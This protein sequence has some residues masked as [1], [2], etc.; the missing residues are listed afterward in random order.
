[1]QQSQEGSRLVSPEVSLP[2]GSDHRNQYAV[3]NHLTGRQYD[4]SNF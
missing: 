2:S 3:P 4:A 1:M